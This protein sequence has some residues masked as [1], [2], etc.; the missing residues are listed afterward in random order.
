MFGL[1][2][3]LLLCF[4]PSLDNNIFKQRRGAYQ[5]L[6]Y[7]NKIFDFRESLR[8]VSRSNESYPVSLSCLRLLE[9]YKEY[10]KLP[11]PPL[12]YIPCFSF[13]DIYYF[14]YM[15]LYSDLVLNGLENYSL[16]EKTIAVMY[17]NVLYDIGYTNSEIIKMLEKSNY[18]Y[19]NK[20]NEEEQNW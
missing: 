2:T 17:I 9:S 10:T 14:H 13:N 15:S 4:I 3:T 18:D 19:N 12:S 11:I 6:N 5:I 7:S 20:D 8:V 16:T 1:I